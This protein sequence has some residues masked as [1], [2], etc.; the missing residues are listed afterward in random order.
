[1][2]NFLRARDAVLSAKIETVEG[3]EEAP[4]AA[5]DS[6]KIE[7]LRVSNNP[8]VLNSNEHTGSLDGSEDLVGGMTVGLSFNVIVKGSGAAGVAP[9]FGDLLKACGFAET[10]TATAVPASAEACGAG[11]SDIVAQLGASA[12]ASADAYNGMPL[13]LTGDAAGESVISDYDTSKNATLTDTMVATV[14]ADSNYQIPINVLYGPASLNIPSLTFHIYRSGIRYKFVGCRGTVSINMQSGD[15]SR[16]AFNFTGMFLSTDDVAVPTGVA[17]DT[18]NRLV[19][20][21]AVMKIER[22]AALVS[23]FSLNFANTLANPDNPNALEGFDPA[24]ITERKI[25]GSVDPTKTLKADRDA[26]GDFRAGNK[27]IVSARMGSVAG[28]RFALTVPQARYLGNDEADREG[29]LTEGL[30]FQAV[31]ADS[32]AYL[33]FY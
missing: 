21:N 20:K 12:S 16:L 4:T 11:G 25:T 17:F 10:I 32:G 1:M 18:A 28:N 27:R 19:W 13:V 31:G 30:P 8:R 24:Q 23:S 14:D 29:I 15:L 26:F 9:E 22:V 7:Q 6:I 2:T 5:T 33:C 3:A